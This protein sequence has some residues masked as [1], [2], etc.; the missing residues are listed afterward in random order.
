MVTELPG[1][2]SQ[3]LTE[4]RIETDLL[5][6]INEST[7]AKSALQRKY[8]LRVTA[9]Q[10]GQ[11]LQ[12]T[13]KG[14][15]KGAPFR[16]E[17]HSVIKIDEDI[18]RGTD[19]HGYLLQQPRKV[20]EIA[21]TLLDPRSQAVP[22]LYL[23]S[24]IWN[25]RPAG[26]AS[27]PAEFTVLKTE[28]PNKPPKY[29]LAFESSAIYLTDSAHRHLAIAHAVRQY[30]EHPARYPT[31][32]PKMEFSVELYMLDTK[33]E[34][35][36]FAELNSKQKKISAAKRKQMDVS[37]PIGSLKDAILEYDR[38][39][40]AFFVD[41][42]EVSSNQNDKHTLMTMSVLY[43]AIDAMFS[44]AD[45]KASR[46]DDDLRQ[47]LAEY[48]CEFF[49]ELSRVIE[50]TVALDEG[51][52]KLHPFRNL[53]SQY[54]AP[55][56][57]TFDPGQQTLSEERQELAVANATRA[58]RE[59]RKKDVFNHNSVIR[60]LSRIAGYIR[61]M[62]NWRLVVQRLQE[63]NA[64]RYGGQMFGD[65]N[66]ELFEVHPAT[67]VSVA[68]RNE[69]GTINV[70]VQTKTINTV[71]EYL[72][73]KLELSRPPEV[74]MHTRERSDIDVL[75]DEPATITLSPDAKTTIAF[76]L[77]FYLPKSVFAVPEE[78]LRLDIDGGDEWKAIT[79]KGKNGGARAG[80]VELDTAYSD[81]MYADIA[82]WRATFELQLPAD[83]AMPN[84][85]V[86]TSVKIQYPRFLDSRLSDSCIR[87][88][89]LT[90]RA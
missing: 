35:E 86:T 61:G 56:V 27:Q 21:E 17:P 22:N 11:W 51:P 87:K 59:L 53:Y 84:P 10:I 2:S 49:Y 65:S 16:I 33:G 28:E 31:F 57:A 60:A 58:N 9:E 32:N 25:V 81:S 73:E 48:F 26:R 20:I 88:T 34:R 55:A 14:R 46:D 5:G 6:V 30:Q 38:S 40:E 85:M 7:T 71:Y 79:A 43:S 45:I 66:R 8:L 37:S 82:K 69:D 52:P 24:L 72:F 47:D 41:N 50:V 23:S 54:I 90:R 19:A 63:L 15:A 78:S 67:G 68:T 77:G 80:S 39:A 3:D 1:Y 74:K 18:Q 29:R 83:Q 42:I 36:L 44:S 76:T 75:G 13:R 62:E 70:Q 12:F 89:I 64:N 4:M